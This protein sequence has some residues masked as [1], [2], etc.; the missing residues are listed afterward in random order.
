MT[1]HDATVAVRIETDLGVFIVDV[2]AGQAPVTAG[3]FLAYVDRNLFDGTSFFRIVTKTNQPDAEFKISVVQGGM[4]VTDPR[5]LPAVEHEPT[6]LSGLHHRNGA[7][8]MA[9]PKDGSGSSSF[10]ICIG[11]QPEL[12]YGG[13]RYEDHEGFAV[14]GYVSKGMDV[15]EKIFARAEDNPYLVHEIGIRRISRV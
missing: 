10:F 4:K 2:N 11:D 14:F 3:N 13:R 6:S 9:R 1:N 7:I 8:S 15:V 12:D 5:A